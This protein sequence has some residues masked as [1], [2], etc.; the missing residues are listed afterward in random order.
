MKIDYK[1]EEDDFLEF[2]L[3]TA[4]KSEQ[5]VKKMRNG[6]IISSLITASIGFYFYWTD[7]MGMAVYLF[8]LAL[9]LGLFYPKYLKWRY[10][11]HY[12][13]HIKEHYSNNFGQL[14]ELDITEFGIASKDKTG[15]GNIKLAEVEEVNETQNHFF[16]KISNGM[17][18]IIPKNI[19]QDAEG[20]KA[21]FVKLGLNINEDYSW[22]W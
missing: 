2:Q 14:T 10:R 1:I 8:I 16:I 9:A 15:E 12:V 19:L 5:I 4:S 11:K 18:I 21:H 20:L 7:E 17:S 13:K 22:K 3:F 6:R